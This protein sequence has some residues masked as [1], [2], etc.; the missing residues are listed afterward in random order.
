M[1]EITINIKIGLAVDEIPEIGWPE[2]KAPPISQN[3]SNPPSTFTIAI[4]GDSD[5][6]KTSWIK[7]LVFLF[8]FY[9]TNSISSQ[10]NLKKNTLVW[11]DMHCV[12]LL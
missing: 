3:I 9:F 2:E 12:L 6:G 5:T 11:D 4:L 10:E 1:S 8:V 7:R